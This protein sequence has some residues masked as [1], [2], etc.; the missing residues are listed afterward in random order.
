MSFMWSYLLVAMEAE[1]LPS[2]ESLQLVE[3]DHSSM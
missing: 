1:A 3:D 2:V